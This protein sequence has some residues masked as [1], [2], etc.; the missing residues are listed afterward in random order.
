MVTNPGIGLEEIEHA[1]QMIGRTAIVGRRSRMER[2]VE[3]DSPFTRSRGRLGVRL[4]QRHVQIAIAHDLAIG[5]ALD[6]LMEIG[7]RAPQA[8]VAPSVRRSS[9]AC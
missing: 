1:E 9:A 4:F 5:V 3:M 7:L 8:M 2:D 6:D